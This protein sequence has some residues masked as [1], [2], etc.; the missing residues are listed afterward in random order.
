VQSSGKADAQ[1]KASEFVDAR[2]STGVFHAVMETDVALRSRRR[3]VP[4]P[5]R[6]GA[7]GMADESPEPQAARA[8]SARAATEMS[9]VM[10]CIMTIETGTRCAALHHTAVPRVISR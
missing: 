7:V 4:R 1:I 2:S 5:G 6:P 9:R 8:Q 3:R 10:V